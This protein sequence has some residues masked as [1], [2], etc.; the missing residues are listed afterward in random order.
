MRLGLAEC[1]SAWTAQTECRLNAQTKVLLA[2]PAWRRG[3]N[4][5]HRRE[6]PQH[7]RFH[8]RR[9]ALPALHHE[10]QRPRSPFHRAQGEL[11]SSNQTRLRTPS[12]RNSFIK[13]HSQT[14]SFIKGTAVTNTYCSNTH[15]NTQTRETS[16]HSPSS[17]SP[18]FTQYPSPPRSLVRDGQTSS[19]RPRLVVSRSTCPPFPP[20]PTRTAL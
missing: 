2:G 14:N 7:S 20:P 12:P 8:V 3:N 19:H 4:C 6:M 5:Q 16:P 11:N 13:K 10:P 17:P 9:T 15:S 1:P 18:S